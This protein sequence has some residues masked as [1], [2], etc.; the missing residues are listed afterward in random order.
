MLQRLLGR[1]VARP[2]ADLAPVLLYQATVAQARNPAFFGE[3]GFPDTVLGRLDVLHLHMFLLARRL[4]VRRDEALAMLSQHVFDRH[5]EALDTALR[6][7]G[8]GDISVPKRKKR[9]V[10]EFYGLIAALDRPFENPDVETVADAVGQRFHGGTRPDVA[11]ALARYLV[12]AAKALSAE[13][14]EAF[15][16]GAVSWPAPAAGIK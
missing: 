15:L 10:R 14:D 11:H 3:F 12:S 1:L 7:L 2:K 5:V 9:M 13:S 6:Q 8:V 4:G 16:A